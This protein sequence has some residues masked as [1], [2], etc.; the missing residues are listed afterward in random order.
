[1]TLP[2]T[3]GLS[4]KWPWRP[5]QARLL[6][7][8]ERH[9]RDGSVTIS[10]RGG[11]FRDQAIFAD[12]IGEVLGPIGNPRYLI[13]RRSRGLA[14]ARTDVH[15]VPTLLAVNRERAQRFHR[16]WQEHV[17]SGDLVYTR[18]KGGRTALLEARGPRAG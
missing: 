4:F 14:G 15:A 6:R 1:V 8:V 13:T 7:T 9:L 12:A 10:L 18:R 17:G 11:T 5:Y 2:P 3:H 16:A